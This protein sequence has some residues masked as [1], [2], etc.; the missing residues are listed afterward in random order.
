MN[1]LFYLLLLLIPC[2]ISYP[3]RAPY[4]L[5]NLLQRYIRQ[6][7]AGLDEFHSKFGSPRQQLYRIMPLHYQQQQQQQQQL[8]QQNPICLPQVWTCGLGLPPCCAGL[9]CYDG[10]AKRG[11]YCVAKG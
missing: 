9:M 2:S 4:N 8:Q 11:R 7:D 6:H 5:N 1:L 10:N 3:R